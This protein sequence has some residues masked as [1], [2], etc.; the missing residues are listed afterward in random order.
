MVYWTEPHNDY[1]GRGLV[2]TATAPVY[3]SKDYTF[4]GVVAADVYIDDLLKLVNERA[5]PN[6]AQRGDSYYFL[7]DAHLRTIAHPL[8]L[9]R[10]SPLQLERPMHS[11]EPV[12]AR[13]WASAHCGAAR[14]AVRPTVSPDATGCGD[15]SST[16]N[17][18]IGD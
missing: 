14:R 5:F 1:A 9:P 17:L 15:L 7:V 13:L 12:R 18:W 11:L 2:V 6:A 16:L 4:I 3:T 8:M 10:S